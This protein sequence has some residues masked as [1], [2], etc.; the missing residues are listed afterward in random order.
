MEILIEDYGVFLGSKGN[1]F[2][3][4]KG[5]EKKA[6]IVSDQAETIIISS[7]GAS[8]STAALRL[9]ISA[10]VPVFISG[11]SGKPYGVLMPI[12]PAVAGPIRTKREQFKAYD[13]GRGLKLAK[14]F[15]GGKLTNQMN[16]LR[17]LAKNRKDTNPK[18]AE[19]LYGASD[20]IAFITEGVEGLEGLSI[21]QTRQPLM[22]L[23]AEAA[24][25]YWQAL[26]Q[27]LPPQFG[28]KGRETR[29]AKDPV[30][31]LLNFGYMTALFP[32][33]WKA[34]VYAG[35]DPYGGF[36]HSDRAGRPSLVLDLMEEFRQPLVDRALLTLIAR[37]ELKAAEFEA[38]EEDRP[39]P[40]EVVGKWSE[41][42]QE[43]LDSLVS[44]G[45]GKMKLRGAVWE[46]ARRAARLVKKDAGE[47]IPFTQGW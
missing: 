5:K 13:D 4:W 17:S 12:A 47:Y 34:V 24:R 41:A 8:V 38:R 26:V 33:A 23:E 18:L 3:I 20:S 9:A 7:P 28:F 16:L 19:E 32:E 40:R 45:E 22:N 10:N 27:I 42:L 25:N 21:E 37:G 31:A 1:R 2:L 6:E 11:Y 15:V 44:Y 46:Q 35:L 30:N 14:G 43:R 36:L 39:L 29:G